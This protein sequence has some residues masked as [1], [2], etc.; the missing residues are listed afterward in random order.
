MA[1]RGTERINFFLPCLFFHAGSTS[2]TSKIESRGSWDTVVASL[3]D[4][5]LS[6]LNRPGLV[7]TLNDAESF[8]IFLWC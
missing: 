8:E 4:E 1:D 6:G 2:S 7:S 5:Q 3:N